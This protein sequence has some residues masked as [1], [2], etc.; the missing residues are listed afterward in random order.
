MNTWSRIRIAVRCAQSA[1]ESEPKHLAPLRPIVVEAL[2]VL[3]GAPTEQAREELLYLLT[4]L[5]EFVVP[6]R[7]SPEPIPGV[8]YVQPG[9]AKSTDEQAGEALALLGSLDLS[10]VTAASSG[11]RGYP[12]KV[13]ISH[14]SSDRVAAE[15][16]IDLLRAALHLQGKDIRCTSVAGYKLPA[17]TQSS[18]QLRSEVFDCEAFV[19]LLSPASMASIYV[20][21]ELG[22][23]WG[24]RRYFVPVMIGK[25]APTDLRP[26]LSDIN[27]IDGGSEPDLHSLISD[28]GER[29]QVGSEGASVYQKA[30]RSFI[31]AATA[32]SMPANRLPG[33]ASTTYQ[34]VRAEAGES[35][36]QFPEELLQV[37][38]GIAE[39]SDNPPGASQL[40]DAGGVSVERMKYYLDTLKERKLINYHLYMGSPATYY[41]TKEG[42]A[43]LVREGRL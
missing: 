27:A 35:V 40:A 24:S 39:C 3:Q 31:Q 4:R 9:W 8:F 12:M 41:L 34:E 43:C 19:A 36:P 18:E 7:P 21:F 25:T 16:F 37:L 22:A 1:I 26:P 38:S 6:W 17:G 42:R 32:V 14:S 10:A 5:Q 30:M 23:R 15:A 2:Q 13:F 29:L 28:L 11:T 20:M 33:M